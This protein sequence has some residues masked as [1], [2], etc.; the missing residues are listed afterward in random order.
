MSARIIELRDKD[1][2]Y[3]Y[4]VT[5]A[6]G[7]YMPNGKDTVG[8]FMR[9]ADDYDTHIEFGNNKITKTM[10]SGSTVVTEFKDSLIVETTT[11][12]GKVIKTKRTT[13]K[14]D[15]TIDIEVN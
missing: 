13:F 5:I 2:Q 10:A 1:K 9:D 8:R 6:D 11:L 15:G 3:I 14:S 4:P 12:D 7:V